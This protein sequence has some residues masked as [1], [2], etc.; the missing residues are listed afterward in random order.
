MLSMYTRFKLT[1]LRSLNTQI[2]RVTRRK[3]YARTTSSKKRCRTQLKALK[4]SFEQQLRELELHAIVNGENL[5][6]S[7]LYGEL[8]RLRA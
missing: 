7:I 2:G 8:M 5:N 1:D 6:D 3:K 4:Q